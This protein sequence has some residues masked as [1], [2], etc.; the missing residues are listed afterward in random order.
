MSAEVVF[1]AP[2]RQKLREYRK[3]DRAGVDQV[4][5]SINLLR[6]DPRPPGSA[7]YG[8]GYFR[9]HVGVYRV[10]YQVRNGTP[11]VI[12]IEHVGKVP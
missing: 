8:S 10:L 7:P 5:D 4:L 9:I 1:Q 12:S 3:N 2:A 11:V 6:G